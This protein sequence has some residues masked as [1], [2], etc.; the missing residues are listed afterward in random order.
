MGLT[1]TAAIAFEAAGGL[2]NAPGTLQQLAVA[3]QRACRRI[4][5]VAR[6]L[7]RARRRPPS[8]LLLD[9]LPRVVSIVAGN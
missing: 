3:N 9:D 2:V 8:I 4:G 1:G 5:N 7:A 6:I